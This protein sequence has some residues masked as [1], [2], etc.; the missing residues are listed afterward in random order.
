MVEPSRAEL[1]YLVER[2]REELKTVNDVGRL[3]SL[4]TDPA[5][6]IRL[7]ASYLKQ[8]F[9]IALCGVLAAAQRRLLVI[10]F[11]NISQ[12]DLASALREIDAKATE[13]L[14][15][16]LRKEPIAPT[17][18]DQSGATGRQGPIGYLRS[19][20][21]SPMK[22][23]GQVTGLLS[24]FSG[25]AEALTKEDCHAID[26][27]ADRLQVAL[28]NAF[29]LDEL[30]QANQL[31][32]DL[33]MVISHELRIPLTSI[34]EGV[35][36]VLEGSLGA[37]T[38]DQQDFLKT[39]NDSAARLDALVEKVVLATRVVTGELKFELKPTDLRPILQDLQ[40][41][42]GGQAQ[43][44]G[45]ALAMDQVPERLPY[46]AD[47][48]ALRTA[49]ANVIEN[50]VQVT[51]AQG[52]VTVQVQ[53]RADGIALEIQ[54]TGPGIP[55]AELPRMFE[56]FRQVGGVDDRKTGGLGLGL[57]L[58]KTIVEGHRG[59]IQLDSRVGQGTRVTIRLPLT[60]AA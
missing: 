21:I 48:Q 19:H 50:A 59:T 13:L 10:Q 17:L 25:K 47:A 7:V 60:P 14:P 37:V 4:T 31:K 20:Y 26:I 32:T 33:L 42:F 49:L 2:Q 5:E 3:L 38:S 58:A 8:T 51:P 12:V 39:V 22:T 18:E 30:R 46:L 52:R 11:A 53:Q 35:N 55:E 54:D 43:A 16:A 40:H 29:L 36:L 44:K 23:G 27:V 1:K 6:I 9:P 56:Q 57:F 24:V 41:V 34:K 15:P 28:R 45:A